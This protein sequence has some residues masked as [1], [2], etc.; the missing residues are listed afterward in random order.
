MSGT[1]PVP[2]PAEPTRC[3][4]GYCEGSD[5]CTHGR[6]RSPL[7]AETAATERAIHLAMNE[8]YEWAKIDA[9]EEQERYR[10]AATRI[11]LSDGSSWPLPNTDLEHTLRYGE[12]DRRELLAAAAILNAYFALTA[13]SIEAKR[14]LVCREIRAALAAP[15]VPLTNERGAE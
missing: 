3:Q 10:G 8:G 9:A 11:V 13:Q 15:A 4:M 1:Q 7:P 5:S 14:N 6:P 2:Q 12:P